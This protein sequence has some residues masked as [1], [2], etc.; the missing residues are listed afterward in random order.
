M[1]VMFAAVVFV[2]PAIFSPRVDVPAEVQFGSASSV[3]F[4]IS[5][6]NATPITGVEYTCELSKLTLANGSEVKDASVVVRSTIRRISG[7]QAVLGRCQTAYL[8]P[9][10]VQAAEYKLTLRYHAYPWPQQR[11]NVYR[12]AAQIRAGQVTGWRLQ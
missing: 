7:R 2:F 5:N 12:I 6:Q 1:V 10:A 3:R 8:V 11:M 9:G 4:Q